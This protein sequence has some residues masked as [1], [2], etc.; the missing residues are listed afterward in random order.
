MNEM[1]INAFFPFSSDY[2]RVKTF[3]LTFAIPEL[4]PGL[5]AGPSYMRVFTVDHA[6]HFRDLGYVF[7][8]NVEVVLVT[9]VVEGLGCS[10]SDLCTLQLNVL[11]CSD[12][13]QGHKDMLLSVIGTQMRLSVEQEN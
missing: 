3:F 1:S 8:V 4:H 6:S 12:G 10:D 13:V 11:S 5:Y 2:I 7:V 9:F